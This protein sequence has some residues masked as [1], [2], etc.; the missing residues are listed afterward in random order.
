MPHFVRPLD[1]IEYEELVLGT[2]IGGIGD[3][4]SLQVGFG[5]LRDG[6]RVTLVAFA[7][8]GLDNVAGN[9]DGRL[10]GK[11]IEHRGIGVGHQNHI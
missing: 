10:V 1:V 7:G 9:V 6:A 4:G 5:A 11:R 2:E 8:S 3:A